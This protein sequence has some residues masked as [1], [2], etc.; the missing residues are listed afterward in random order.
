[1]PRPLIIDK[2]SDTL[3]VHTFAELKHSPWDGDYYQCL[4]VM[5]GDNSVE[6]AANKMSSVRKMLAAFGIFQPQIETVS[7]LLAMSWVM[8]V[9]AAKKGVEV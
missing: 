7:G 6:Q 2:I 9:N 1:M 8:G 4:A 5:P 3:R